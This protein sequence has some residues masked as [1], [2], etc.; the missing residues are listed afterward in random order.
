MTFS[1][2]VTEKNIM[3]SVA[4]IWFGLIHATVCFRFIGWLHILLCCEDVNWIDLAQARHSVTGFSGD[5][6]ADSKFR[7]TMV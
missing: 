2:I 5:S 3:V 6:N 4:F 1:T 7:H